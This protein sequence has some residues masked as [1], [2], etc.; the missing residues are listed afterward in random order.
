VV[1]IEE[2]RYLSR[3]SKMVLRGNHWH[4]ERKRAKKCLTQKENGKERGKKNEDDNN[5]VGEEGRKVMDGTYF[6]AK[7]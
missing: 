2:I 4:T 3:Q 6:V 7:Q 1:E 5:E